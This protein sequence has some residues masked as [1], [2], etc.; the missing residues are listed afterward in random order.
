MNGPIEKFQPASRF[1]HLNPDEGDLGEGILG[2]FSSLTYRGKIWK[3]RHA[4]ETYTFTREDDGT[5]IPYIDVVILNRSP[6][7]SQVYYAGAF[8]EDRND[9]PDCASLRGDV[10][11]PGVPSPQS[12]TCA[13]CSH[14]QWITKP[15]GRR[16]KECQ[17]H[18]RVAV[19]LDPGMMQRL[20]GAPLLEPVY[21]KIP[22]ASLPAFKKYG[23]YLKDRRAH[24]AQLVTRI[25]FSP[26]KIFQLTFTP[27]KKLADTDADVILPLID[28]S[29]TQQVIGTSGPAV[30][31]EIEEVPFEPPKK[32]DKPVAFSG[33]ISQAFA[34]SAMAAV[35]TET[36]GGNS[37][38]APAKR[39]RPR[40]D[41]MRELED[42]AKKG[43][44][45]KAERV[46]D[47]GEVLEDEAPPAKVESW[48][49]SDEELDRRVKAMSLTKTK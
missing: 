14:F 25:G 1:A 21:L 3:L 13:M 38:T 32:L 29:Q 40:K 6:Y 48:E 8:E 12:E 35:A 18:R 46:S 30:V 41:A 49:E 16:G 15:D 27:G 24:P 23:N 11:D 5:P 4:G 39:G 47:D 28:S 20:I 2:G 44:P 43:E 10:P 9:P 7:L 45:E 26:D 31:H 19:F 34:G 17:T 36:A 22:P 42:M 33:S 37:L